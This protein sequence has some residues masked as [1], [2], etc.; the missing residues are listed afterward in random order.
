ML[1]QRLA[2]PSFDC[3]GAPLQLPVAAVG[4]CHPFFCELAVECLAKLAALLFELCG[5]L[6]TFRAH[7]AFRDLDC[8]P[9][10][11]KL[12]VKFALDKLDLRRALPKL[13][14]LLI[15]LIFQL[16]RNVIDAAGLDA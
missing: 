9:S 3:V 2:L 5:A 10:F 11:I 4:R 8:G 1:N 6:L 13:S 15:H 16:T 7:G 14:L 12:A